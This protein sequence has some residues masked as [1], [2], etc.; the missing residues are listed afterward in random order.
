MHIFGLVLLATVVLSSTIRQKS[1][2]Q[3][4]AV[5]NLESELQSSTALK[6]TTVLKTT[7]LPDKNR[8]EKCICTP[9]YMCKSYNWTVEV[10]KRRN[11]R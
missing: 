2:T 4:T 6:S 9:Y 1:I 5:G 10:N 7:T 11:L 8:D 3:P